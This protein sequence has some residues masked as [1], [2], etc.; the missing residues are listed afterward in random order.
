MSD[1]VY[2]VV[3]DRMI[4]RLQAGVVPWRK[5][6]AQGSG[7]GE[8]KS[9]VSQSAYRGVNAF[10][11]ALAG[12]SSPWFLTFKQ[13]QELG[14]T[15]KAGEKGLPIVF[16]GKLE[17]EGKEGADP[18]RIPF[19]RY[20]TVFNV[21]QCEG[22]R[23][24][25]SLLYP[26][27][28]IQFEPIAACESIRDGMPMAPRIQHVD[29]SAYYSP[30]LDYVNMPARESFDSPEAY[31]ATLF[32]ELGHS[33]GHEN[34]LKRKTLKDI[35]RFGDHAY[36]QG[37]LV[38]EMTAAFLCAK[39]GISP[40]TEENSAAYLAAWIKK[41]REEP[42]ILIQSAAQAQKAADFILNIKREEKTGA[43]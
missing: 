26:T 22:L 33:T 16:W 17:R 36:S 18:E 28:R 25:E 2:Q 9:L 35:N 32:H 40:A 23:V 19:I 34:R 4:E 27:K 3:T 37:E 38:A 8:C 7:L 39:V 42:R 29:S 12:Y 14:A 41:L 31:Y 43:A 6:W 30:R 20:Y 1:K 21:E 11:T 5:T 15:V 24:K 13:A 10:T